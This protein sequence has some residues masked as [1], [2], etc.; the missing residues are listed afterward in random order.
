M[1]G[2]WMK[3]ELEMPDKPEVHSIAAMLNI[4]PDAVVGKLIRVW[5]WFDKHT[6]DGNA[7]GV[8]YSLVD[9]ITGV[10]GMGEAMMFVGWL[11]QND[12]TLTMPK[13]DR[14]TSKSAKTR[15][16][17]QKRVEKK[18]NAD[19]TPEALLREEKRRVIKPPISP[20]GEFVIP[21]WIPADLWKDYMETRKVLKS[22]MTDRAKQLA[23]KKLDDL[24]AE[25]S[26][27][28]DVLSQSIYNGWKG[29][30]PVKDKQTAA[31]PFAGALHA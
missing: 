10:T 31:D 13:F 20:K 30:F 8:T 18:R 11:E 14:H 2:D 1:A 5:Q 24:R 7:Y 6:V 12:K 22:P 23:V 4:D 21:D 17:T 25:G 3:I 16:L 27:P 19:V 26:S 28:T 29:L 15:A 9:R